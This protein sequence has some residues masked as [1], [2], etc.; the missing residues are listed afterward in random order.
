MPP[1]L[2]ETGP[3]FK[4]A[5]LFS[6]VLGLELGLRKF[7]PKFCSVHSNPLTN[8][9]SQCFRPVYAPVFAMPGT[10]KVTKLMSKLET[11]VKATCR[12]QK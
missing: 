10:W 4:V 2:Q 8:S 3:K 5:S 11:N 7:G 6:G 1:P 9:L 12:N